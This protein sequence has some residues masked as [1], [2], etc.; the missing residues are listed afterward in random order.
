LAD[1]GMGAWLAALLAAIA[2]AALVCVLFY[3]L[4]VRP[5]L[6]RQRSAV[7]E[8]LLRGEAAAEAL[9]PTRNI[10]RVQDH[11]LRAVANRDKPKRVLEIKRQMAAAGLDWSVSRYAV[12][13][14]L[15]AALVWSAALALGQSFA[16]ATLAAAAAG[17]FLPKKALA[18]LAERRKLKF[19]DAFA[20]AV[21]M[22]VRGARSG[23]ALMDCLAMVAADAEDPVRRE[24]ETLLSQLRGGIPLPAAVERLSAVMPAPEVRFFALIMTIQN[25]TGGNLT[26]AL[27]NLSAVLRDRQRLA[28]K[29]R[30]ASAEARISAIIIASLPF[31]VIG[32][33]AAIAPAYIAFLWTD[34]A[35]Q[36]LAAFCAVWLALGILVIRRMA[37]IQP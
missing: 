35:G 21:D 5:S 27:G 34:E 17:W 14:A 28:I 15:V 20:A 3:P 31:C 36:N 25:Q 12:W 8:A 26:E 10:R 13:C 1:A 32:A 7:F 4:L 11:A 2:M 23:L 18:A 19:L 24:F 37:R 30:V 9:R 29:V 16:P 33:T 6:A 22:I